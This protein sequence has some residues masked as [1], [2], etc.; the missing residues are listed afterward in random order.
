M[1]IKQMHDEHEDKQANLFFAVIKENKRTI[2]RGTVKFGQI[3]T[4]RNIG[5][6]LSTN[7]LIFNNFT[8]INKGDIDERTTR[9]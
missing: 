7:S 8:F 5:E 3:F 6:Y 2:I 1:M 4:Y 9:D